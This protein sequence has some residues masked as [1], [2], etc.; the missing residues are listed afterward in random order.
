MILTLS[1][2]VFGP[3]NGGTWAVLQGFFSGIRLRFK[4]LSHRGR[5]TGRSER[6]DSVWLR[7]GRRADRMGAWRGR[8]GSNTKGP[9]IT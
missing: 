5:G 7:C 2:L 1:S 4:V 3:E 9:C 6:M 8:S